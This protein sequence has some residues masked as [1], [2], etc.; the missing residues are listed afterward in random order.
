M[1]KATAVKVPGKLIL[2]G[3]HA[4]VHGAPAL[5]CAI[6]VYATASCTPHHQNHLT[7]DF[8]GTLSNHSLENL[9]TIKNT[10]ETHSQQY[11]SGQRTI[12]SVLT[13]PTDLPLYT[14]ALFFSHYAIKPQHSLSLQSDIPP[15][16]GMGASAA[17]IL[18][19]LV[20][21]HKAHDLPY[22]HDALFTMAQH[23]ESI[24]HGK[25]SG[26]DVHTCL[27]GG[28]WHYHNDQKQRVTLAPDH[29]LH[30]CNTGPADQSTGQCVDHVRPHFNK[31]A[32]ITQ[33]FKQATEDMK[34]SLLNHSPKQL[35]HAIQD[36]H[37]L[38]Y[39]IGAV[40]NT[41]HKH[42]LSLKSQGIATKI[43]GAGA[44]SGQQ[45]GCLIMALP[46]AIRPPKLPWKLQ[47]LDICHRGAHVSC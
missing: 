3:E 19:I 44:V 24:Q 10:T 36:N 27:Q 33:A 9:T 13:H 37:D 12:A 16:C 6:P 35:Q 21:L 26:I 2:S 31:D 41:I 29:G 1:T 39:Q 47:P 4:V 17:I 38:L 14:C 25:S 5:A 43:S 15:H 30:W 42:I 45:A 8:N 40:P 34:A 18:A 22:N 46:Q 20:A 23:A 28:I 32:N 7:A 11:L